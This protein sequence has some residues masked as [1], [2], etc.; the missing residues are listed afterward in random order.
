MNRGMIVN[1]SATIHAPGFKVCGAL[2]NPEL[3]G[4]Q[5]HRLAAC[6]PSRAQSV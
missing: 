3:F 4:T 5:S 1:V 2:V 6:T